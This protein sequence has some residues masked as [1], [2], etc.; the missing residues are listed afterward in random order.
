M[1]LSFIPKLADHDRLVITPN[2]HHPPGEHFRILIN[3]QVVGALS[4]WELRQTLTYAGHKT[5][6]AVLRGSQSTD[7]QG[8]CGVFVVGTDVTAQC[9]AISIQPYGMG[10]YPTSYMGGYSR[11][12]GDAY[13]THPMFPT[14]LRNCWID[15]NQAVFEFYNPLALPAVMACYGAVHLK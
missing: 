15:G 7:I 4:V 12:H 13:L 10:G 6:R 3:A 2:N 9:S 5:I 1:R 11:L 14:I 8:H